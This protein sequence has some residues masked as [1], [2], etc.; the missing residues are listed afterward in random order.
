VVT[1]P[2]R[3]DIFNRDKGKIAGDVPGFNVAAIQ[4]WP[5]SRTAAC[6]PPVPS[7]RGTQCKALHL[8]CAHRRRVIRQQCGGFFANEM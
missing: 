4:P 8:H 6:V 5:Y 7:Y 2:T 3:P 1:V